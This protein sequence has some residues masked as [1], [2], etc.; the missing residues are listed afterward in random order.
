MNVAVPIY[1]EG[2]F[3]WI[4]DKVELMFAAFYTPTLL[5]YVSGNLADRYGGKCLVMVRFLGYES[6][7]LGMTVVSAF[8]KTGNVPPLLWMLMVCAG[9]SLAFANTPVMAE[10]MYSATSKRKQHPWP[11][12][13][14]SGYGM[15]YGVGCLGNEKRKAC[16]RGDK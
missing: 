7:F 5:C 16:R 11:Q 6:T 4:S 13:Y 12:H 15:T 2:K 10:T 9:I 14:S 8:E 1:F 3:K